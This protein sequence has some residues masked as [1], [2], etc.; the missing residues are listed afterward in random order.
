MIAFGESPSSANC[1]KP[2]KAERE[3]DFSLGSIALIIFDSL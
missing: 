2:K 1:A 3:A